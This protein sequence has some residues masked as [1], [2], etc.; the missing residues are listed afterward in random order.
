MKTEGRTSFRRLNVFP[1]TA[2]HSNWYAVT[3]LYTNWL[4]LRYI[5][6]CFSERYYCTLLKIQI[7]PICMEM[8]KL[9]KWLGRKSQILTW[10]KCVMLSAFTIFKI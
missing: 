1:Q 8:Q 9:E 5:Q 10:L 7:C 6:A 4:R 3:C 2:I